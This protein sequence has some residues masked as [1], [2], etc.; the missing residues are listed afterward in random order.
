MSELLLAELDEADLPKVNIPHGLISFSHLGK[1]ISQYHIPSDF[2]YK[3]PNSNEFILTSGPLKVAFCKET[4][5]T[6]SRI[7]LYPFITWFLQKYGFV[8]PQIHLNFKRSISNYLIK[9]A[10]VGHPSRIKA[11]W[12]L[13]ILKK[14]PKS[15]SY[16]YTSHRDNFLSL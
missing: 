9:L 11:M 3:V 13:I 1:I 7:L 4:F 12:S 8:P 5:Q 2:V 10:K 6:W 16:Y 14:G 15:N